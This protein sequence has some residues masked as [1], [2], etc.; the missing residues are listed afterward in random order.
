MTT[1][2][3]YVIPCEQKLGI[4]YLSI[5]TLSNVQLKAK[6]IKILKIQNYM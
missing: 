5:S 6:K 1:S 4:S 2:H 3:F